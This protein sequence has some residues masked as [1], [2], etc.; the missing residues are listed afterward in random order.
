VKR[1]HKAVLQ[2]LLAHDSQA[3][4]AVMYVGLPLLTVAVLS[5]QLSCARLLLQRGADLHAVNVLTQQLEMQ[6][7]PLYWSVCNERGA[8]MA[9]LLLQHGAAVNE[10]AANGSTPLMG[11]VAFSSAEC[12]QVLLN[13]GAD[14]TA[15]HVNGM[16]VLH[17]AVKNS[18]HPEVLQ[19]LSEQ[20]AAAAKID[21]MA[22]QHSALAVDR[23]LL[24]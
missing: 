6:N 2:L 1:G 12:V 18:K 17:T 10:R 11:A 15:Q 14:V 3:A 20:N 24:L 4:L 8:A 13:A 19:L 9:A 23:E 5:E 22:A 16:T 7:S 21:N